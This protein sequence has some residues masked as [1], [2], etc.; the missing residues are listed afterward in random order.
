MIASRLK[1]GVSAEKGSMRVTVL[2]LLLVTPLQI[3]SDQRPQRADPPSPGGAV[4]EMQAV[5]AARRSAALQQRA[6]TRRQDAP[7]LPEEPYEQ[8]LLRQPPGHQP[9]RP[10]RPM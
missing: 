10:G 6:E 3:G 1:A 4:A 9:I 2:A 5:V 7:E 8:D